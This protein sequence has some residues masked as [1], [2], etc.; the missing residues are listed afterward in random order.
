M[1]MSDNAAKQKINLLGLF[2]SIK[3]KIDFRRSHPFYFDPDG[4]LIF[5][6][7]QGSGKTLSAVQYVVNL[8]RKY[9]K[10]ILVTNIDITEYPIVDFSDYCRSHL[11]ELKD[12]IEGI[13]EDKERDRVLYEHYRKHNRV[14]PF[15]NDDDLL[16]YTNGEMGVIYLIDEIQ[17]YMN[18]LQSKNI[19]IDKITLLSQQRKQRLHI[20]GTS[21]LFSRLAK[22]IR[23]Q[24]SNIIHCTC[25]FGLLQ[26]NRMID[27]KSI[28][29]TTTDVNQKIKAKVKRSYIWFHD[30]SY[31]HSYDTYD[32]INKIDW[33]EVSPFQTYS[34][35]S[36]LP[37]SLL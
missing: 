19:S 34:E 6:G 1:P 26:R 8:L 30:P 33:A 2:K 31:Y 28:E 37:S 25:Y 20:V 36:S 10:C 24:F 12:A 13:D 3:F 32:V 7:G 22:P 5:F 35:I 14:F 17:V 23:E 15:Y 9:P 16:R 29:E 21:Q 18:S 27:R 11:E 4:T